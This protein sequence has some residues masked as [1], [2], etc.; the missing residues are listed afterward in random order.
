MSFGKKVIFWWQWFFKF[1]FIAVSYQSAYIPL[2]SC[3]KPHLLHCDVIISK[4]Q[5]EVQTK[6]SHRVTVKLPCKIRK[7]PKNCLTMWLWN[8][9]K[10]HHVKCKKVSHCVAVKFEEEEN[11]RQK[12]DCVWLSPC[13]MQKSVSLCDCVWLSP[14]EMQTVSLYI[15]LWISPCE[16]E[17]VLSAHSQSPSFCLQQ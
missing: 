1:A 7:M 15:W 17:I 8:F 13:E 5:C 12:T 11:Q 4:L 14:C 9:I 2:G 3:Q 6:L 16:C 10:I